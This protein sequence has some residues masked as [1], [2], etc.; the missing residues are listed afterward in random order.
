M[1]S[2]KGFRMGKDVG[3]PMDI[4][5]EYRWNVPVITY[6]FDQSFLDY[7]GTNGV[8]AATPASGVHTSVVSAESRPASMRVTSP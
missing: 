4:N 7:F 8:I 5:A 6:G 2:T 3:G 1:D